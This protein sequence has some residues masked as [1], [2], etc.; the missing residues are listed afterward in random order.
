MLLPAG[1]TAAQD[2]GLARR[3]VMP[4]L[5]EIASPPATAVLPNQLLKGEVQTNSVAV[6][7]IL[8]ERIRRTRSAALVAKIAVKVAI[9]LVTKIQQDII[10]VWRNQILHRA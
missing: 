3:A 1:K 2:A 9:N 8:L 4:T 7:G 5:P 6:T 10:R